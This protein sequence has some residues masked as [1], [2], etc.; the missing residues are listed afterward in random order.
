MKNRVIILA[1]LA[2]AALAA[3]LYL[4]TPGSPPAGQKAVIA[5]S[6]ANFINFE[7]AFDSRSDS[8]RLVLLL[9]P[10]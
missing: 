3:V 6:K 5:L 8:P 4:R 9:S 2:I 1:V 7:N 10:T